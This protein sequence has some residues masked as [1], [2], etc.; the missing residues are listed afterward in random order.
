MNA[1]LLTLHFVGLIMAFSGAI[2]GIVADGLRR[3]ATVEGAAALAR[4]PAAMSK[5]EWTGLALLLVTGP[6]M[7]YSKHGGAWGAM[8]W[9][10]WVKLAGVLVLIAV[11]V[12]LGRLEARLA[13]G[14]TAVEGT[15]R[16]LGPIAGL[17][18]LTALVFA[19]I[20]FD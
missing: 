16:K 1:V 11:I 5:V 12:P 9:T 20:T 2:G 18:A 3:Q 10:F 6:A 7:I 17:G 4:F 15:I 13:G 14:E 8:P 19:V